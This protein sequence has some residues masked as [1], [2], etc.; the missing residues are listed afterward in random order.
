MSN[1]NHGIKS[2]GAPILPGIGG[3]VFTG[4]VYFVSSVSAT[5]SDSP[6]AGKKEAPFATIDYAIG[7][8]TANNGDIIICMPG[9]VETVA[10]DNGLAIDIAGITLIGVG[11]GS[12]RPTI[13]VTVATADVEISAANTTMYNF[14]FTGGIDVITG[15]INISAADCTLLNFET[16]DVTGEATD[17]IVTTAAAN[18]LKISGWVHNGATTAGADTA[19]SIVGGDGIVVE[20]FRIFG[21]F[22]VA[23]IENVTTAMTNATIGGGM[24]PN[25]IQNGYD[26]TAVVAITVVSTST[27]HIGPNIHARIGLDSTSNTTNITEAFVGAAMQFFQPLNV[28][29]LGGEVA[30]QSNI[31]ASTDG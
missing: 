26:N 29:N 14:L 28:A 22:A 24:K 17:F 2:F 23:A 25:Y 31:T 21:N 3:N 11:N 9:H 27:G 10:V 7:R 1:F 5:R 4:D 19:L 12:L 18:R 6:S 20:D 16:R 8:C 13:N 30:M 15:V